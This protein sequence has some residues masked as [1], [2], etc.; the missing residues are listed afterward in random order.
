MGSA[1]PAWNSQVAR[2]SSSPT[3]RVVD[4]A[5]ATAAARSGIDDV[6]VAMIGRRFGMKGNE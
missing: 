3:G 6:G 2:T 5:V 4:E 1:Q